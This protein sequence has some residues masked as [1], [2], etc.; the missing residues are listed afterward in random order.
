MHCNTRSVTVGGTRVRRIDR[1][2]NA[3][4]LIDAFERL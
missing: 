2:G 1:I 4:A 3:A